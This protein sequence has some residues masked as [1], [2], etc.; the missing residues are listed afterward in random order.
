MCAQRHYCRIGVEYLFNWAK[1][2]LATAAEE[3]KN[4]QATSGTN[5][6]YL[7]MVKPPKADD[8]HPKTRQLMGC[9][10]LAMTDSLPSEW[11]KLD[12][13]F[14]PAIQK[15]SNQLTM[16]PQSQSMMRRAPS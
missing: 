8:S 6:A 10:V 12:G 7:W 3:D 11:C 13:P 4:G 1:A 9:A 2:A 5:A 16:R 14:I 15:P